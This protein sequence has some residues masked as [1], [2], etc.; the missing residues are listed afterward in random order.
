MKM[1]DDIQ[2]IK[3]DCTKRKKI[4]CQAMSGPQC[5]AEVKV[6]IEKKPSKIQTA[7]IKFLRSV[8]GYTKLIKWKLTIKGMT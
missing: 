1:H 8:K 6:G 2:K 5:Y 4:L 3:Q 7:R